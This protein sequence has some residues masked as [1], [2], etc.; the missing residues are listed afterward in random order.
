MIKGSGKM[1]VTARQ[2]FDVRKYSRLVSKVAP[3]IIET[4]A[5]FERAD[6]EVG[7]LLRKG[8]DKLSVEERRLL[9]L[10]SRL[11]EDYEDRTFPVPDSP[12]HRTL[13]FLMEQNDLRQA[14]LVNI[15]GSRG[16]VSEVVNGK[17]A[18]SKSQAKALG[19]FFKVSPELFI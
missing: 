5:E 17:R 16:R 2:K 8:Y 4:E 18:I 19:E 3:L 15:F 11:I 9:A 10:L 12:P 6:A 13:Q 7:R 1:T 14:D